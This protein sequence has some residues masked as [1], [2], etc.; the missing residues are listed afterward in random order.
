MSA[1]TKQPAPR[2]RYTGTVRRFMDEAA[3]GFITRDDTGTEAFVG[4]RQLLDSGL[5]TL[6][7]G[8]RVSFKLFAPKEPGRLPMAVNVRVLDP[9][10]SQCNP[11]K[12]CT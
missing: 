3:L 11:R 7:D 1:S 6:F 10:P 9:R 8:Q 4:I 2:P 5:E 12:F